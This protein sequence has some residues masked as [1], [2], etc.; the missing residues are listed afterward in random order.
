MTWFQSF[1]GKSFDAM[2][3]AFG[4]NTIAL[5][6]G[7]ATLITPNPIVEY[8]GPM[9]SDEPDPLNVGEYTEAWKITI[10]EDTL[11][12]V[13]GSRS[14]WEAAVAHNQLWYTTVP[15]DTAWIAVRT[16]GDPKRDRASGRIELMLHARG[17]DEPAI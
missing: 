9:S 14:A 5:R 7:A 4:M 13:F 2:C 12:A 6:H 8:L 1:T 15:N 17:I 3:S 11:L 10:P 16:V